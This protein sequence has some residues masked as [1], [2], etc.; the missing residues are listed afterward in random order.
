MTIAEELK[1]SNTPTESVITIGVFDGV[2]LGHQHLINNLKDR[3]KIL[4]YSSGVITFKNHPASIINPNFKP[5][6][7][8]TLEHRI[9]L[10]R[11]TE[12]DF[13]CPI[14]FN[15]EVASL[16]AGDFIKLLQ[17]HLGMKM[18]VVGPDFQ[19]G[20]DREANVNELYN[21]GSRLGFELEVVE[22]EQR[23]GISVR[24][25]ELR[26][27][28][29]QGNIETVSLMLGRPFSITGKVVEGFKRGR[30]IGFPTANLESEI[31]IAVPKNGIYSTIATVSGK[32]YMAASSIGTRPTF[33]NGSRTIE[34]FILDF[35]EIIYGETVTLE[36]M[37]RLR[38]E[39]KYDSLEE[40]I[41]QINDDVSKT[42]NSLEH[43]MSYDSGV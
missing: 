37:N 36:F 42:R 11:S 2:H 19:M 10:L 18:L 1:I 16:R 30:E 31:G 27:L 5:D 33:D 12:I 32:R 35:D 38:D 25:T 6:F 4:Q 41:T 43:L 40:L 14:T 17:E 39:I 26:K 34:A 22:V 3:A 7:V 24:S 8:T 29:S 13:V 23:N 15:D 21:L 28:L 20:K 9:S